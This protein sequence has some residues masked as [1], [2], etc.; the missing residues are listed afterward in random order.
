VRLAVRLIAAGACLLLLVGCREAGLPEPN[1]ERMIDQARYRPYQATDLF[2]DG[3]VM[4][5]PPEGTVHRDAPAGEPGYVEGLV[6]GEWLERI[7]VPV[8]REL[9]ARGR[10]RFEVF[11]AACHGVAGDGVSRVAIAMSLRRPP[12]LHEDRIREYPP[13]RIVQVIR[14]GYGLMPD[15]AQQLREEDR[16][17]VA[18]YVQAL[19]LSQRVAL[20]E[21]PPELRAEAARELEP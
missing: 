20:D 21:L 17:A 8:T 7:P 14:E 5:P 11:C 3:R 18:A 10:D 19:Q 1:F 6:A 12:S 2:P 16:W 15:F 9:L 4:R 13:G